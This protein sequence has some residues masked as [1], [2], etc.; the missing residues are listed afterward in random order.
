MRLPSGILLALSIVVI[1]FAAPTTAHA[2][3]P[4][5]YW[6]RV[7]GPFGG[8]YE[9]PYAMDRIPTPPYFAIHPPVYYSYPVPRTY[10]Y[11]PYA[12]PGTVMTPDLA[13]PPVPAEII[14]PHVKPSSREAAEK[15]KDRVTQTRSQT[16]INPYA[17][18]P[19]LKAGVDL[20]QL[21][22]QKTDHS[23]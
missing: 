12:Y 18:N 7:G 13:K 22:K 5:D 14:N 20:A 17:G 10:G 4:M 16:I 23:R 9:M 15:A 21:L 1:C 8:W 3:W 2:Q 19:G 11:S 6:A